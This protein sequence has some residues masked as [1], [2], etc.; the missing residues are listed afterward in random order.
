VLAALDVFV[1]TS[2]SEGLSGA[3]L[4]AMAA[5][6]PIVATG[7]VENRELVTDGETATLV[8]T[9]A[10]DAVARAVVDLLDDPTRAAT[11]GRAAQ[12]DAVDR[13]SLERM[14]GNFEAF[15]ESVL[16]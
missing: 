13:F 14:V 10:P 11:L 1:F 7:I 5:G 8:P 3:L 9:H 2:Y 15:Y 12:R 6:K 4:E 16:D